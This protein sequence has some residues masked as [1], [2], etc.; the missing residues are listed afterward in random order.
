M[1]VMH[2]W[3]ALS[4]R[5]W[6]PAGCVGIIEKQFAGEVYGGKVFTSLSLKKKRK[7]KKKEKGRKRKRAIDSSRSWEKHVLTRGIKK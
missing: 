2:L 5:V 4:C 1:Q 3:A 7:K 6:L